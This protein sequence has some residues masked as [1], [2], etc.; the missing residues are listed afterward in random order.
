[1]CGR[2]NDRLKQVQHRSY[3]V[4]SEVLICTDPNGGRGLLASIVIS[5]GAR[6]SFHA[7]P[8]ASSKPRGLLAISLCTRCVLCARPRGIS[9]QPPTGHSCTDYWT[10]KFH[11]PSGA[12][13]PGYALPLTYERTRGLRLHFLQEKG[14]ASEP[15]R[16]E[17]V[18]RSLRRMHRGDGEKSFPGTLKKYTRTGS[19]ECDY[20]PFIRLC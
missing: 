3:S 20:S 16:Y 12:L 14:R 19:R 7:S 18:A 10:R 2:P 11:T 1:V 8:I 9:V 13:P 15:A 4:K 6:S 5:D 17:H